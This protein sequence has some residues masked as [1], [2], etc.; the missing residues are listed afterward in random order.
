[1]RKTILFA[2]IIACLIGLNVSVSAQKRKSTTKKPVVALTNEPKEA[3]KKVEIQLNNVVK[4]L[5]LLGGIASGIEGIDKDVKS[6]KISARSKVANDN[7]TFKQNVLLGIRN[8]RTGLIQLESE[9]RVKPKLQ[10]YLASIQGIT[11]LSGTAEDLA[12]SGNFTNSG[13]T[14][15]LVIEKLTANLVALP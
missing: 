2:S 3:A 14:L 5:Y 1:M 13:K 12:L 6:G 10:P 4:F 9:F 11:E 15:L 7:E 8:L